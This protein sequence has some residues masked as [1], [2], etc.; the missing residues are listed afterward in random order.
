VLRPS[1]SPPS[2]ARAKLWHTSTTTDPPRLSTEEE[3]AEDAALEIADHR[4]DQFEATGKGGNYG[5][6]VSGPLNY[7]FSAVVVLS[8]LLTIGMF[9]ESAQS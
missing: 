7:A 8:D 5:P 4:R 2:L 6:P 9:Q 3:T 1:S